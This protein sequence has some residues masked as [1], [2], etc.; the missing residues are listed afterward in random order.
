MQERLESEHEI[1]DTTTGKPIA[2][3]ASKAGRDELATK[4]GF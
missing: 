1:F 2:P 3:S 4:V